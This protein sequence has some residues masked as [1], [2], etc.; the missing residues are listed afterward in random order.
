MLL[1]IINRKRNKRFE[2]NMYEEYVCVGCEVG[3]SVV[4]DKAY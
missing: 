4:D 3:S 1:V 2:K